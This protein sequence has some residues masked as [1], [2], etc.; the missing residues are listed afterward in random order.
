[1]AYRFNIRAILKSIIKKLLEITLPLIIY[2]NLKLLYNFLV[3]LGIIQEKR[4]IIDIIC[5]Y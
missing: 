1:M 5:L 2:T 4:L 3:K